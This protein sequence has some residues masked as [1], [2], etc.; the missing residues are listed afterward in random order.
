[1]K[2]IIFT[3]GRASNSSLDDLVEAGGNIARLTFSYGSNDTQLRRAKTLRNSAIARNSPLQIAGELQGQGL[4]VG[5]VS[6]VETD[7]VLPIRSGSQVEFRDCPSVNVS[8]G[9][10]FV[11]VPGISCVDVRIGHKLVYGDHKCIFEVVSIDDGRLMAIAQSSDEIASTRSVLISGAMAPQ[12]EL[13]NKNSTQLDFII[14]NDEFDIVILPNVSDLDLIHAVRRRIIDAGSSLKIACRV[15]T[16]QP[17]KFLNEAISICDYLILDRSDLAL[18]HGVYSVP[19]IVRSM[20]PSDLSKRSK[21][22][23]ASQVAQ[24][25]SRGSTGLLSAAEISDAWEMLEQGLGGFMLGEETAVDGNGVSAVRQLSSLVS[26]FMS[27]N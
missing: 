22:L 5:Q 21:V 10:Q 17:C 16:F 18:T 4:R 3:I 25:A 2:N 8:S 12:M 1:M 14:Q 20:L 27:N 11:P 7:G 9:E 15:G 26:V 13:D 19:K 6:A 24:S 23:I